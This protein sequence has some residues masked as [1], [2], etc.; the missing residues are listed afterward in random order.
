MSKIFKSILGLSLIF[1]GLKGNAQVSAYGF[2]H[3]SGTYNQIPISGPTTTAIAIGNQDDNVY[4][5][6]PIGFNFNFNG[7]IINLKHS[8]IFR[9]SPQ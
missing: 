8:V 1:F 7:M 3:V 6:V 9:I 4:N 5:N 2:S